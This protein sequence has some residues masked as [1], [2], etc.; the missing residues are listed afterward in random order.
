MAKEDYYKLLGVEKDASSEEIKS[1]YRKMALKY[2]PD[3]NPDDKVAEER[4][5]E[6]SEA[7][8]VL[9]DAQ[10][11]SAYD[12]FGHAGVE[13]SFGQGGFQWGDFSQ[14]DLSQQ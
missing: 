8:E 14:A 12:Q 5:R 4:F 10:K 2:H 9:S 3:R 13:N 6:M 7:Y 11:K 1:A